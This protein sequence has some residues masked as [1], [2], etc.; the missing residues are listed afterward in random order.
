MA[1]EI[2]KLKVRCPACRGWARWQENPNRPFCSPECKQRD[3]GNW[4]T[5][6]YRI[7]VRQQDPENESEIAPRH[8]EE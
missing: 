2:P 6:K 8:P 4:A 5:E 3:L 7:P 1:D